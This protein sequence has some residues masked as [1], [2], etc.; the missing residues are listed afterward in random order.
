[1]TSQANQKVQ[2]CDWLKDVFSYF[3]FSALFQDEQYVSFV[4]VVNVD[5]GMCLGLY[6][7]LS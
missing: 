6:F 5:Q 7:I 4:S 2:V 3:F 1:M